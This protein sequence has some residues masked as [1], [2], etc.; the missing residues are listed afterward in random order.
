M[1]LGRVSAIQYACFPPW[2]KK[3]S[4]SRLWKSRRS[5]GGHRREETSIAEGKERKA[6]WQGEREKGARLSLSVRTFPVRTLK[7]LAWGW[8]NDRF[9]LHESGIVI[10]ARCL[11][12]SSAPRNGPFPCLWPALARIRATASSFFIAPACLTSD[13]GL[14]SGQVRHSR[15]L[16]DVRVTG[17]ALIAGE[18]LSSVSALVQSWRFNRPSL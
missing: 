14:S 3:R 8:K 18:L 5:T 11:D 1:L 6:V 12:L 13:S 16:I 9:L 7:A 2:P 10:V 15:A 4:T 17:S